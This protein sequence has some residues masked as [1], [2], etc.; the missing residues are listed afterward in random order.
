MTDTNRIELARDIEL[1]TLSA[2]RTYVEGDDKKKERA[3]AEHE[4][5]LAAFI[6]KYGSLCVAG[7]R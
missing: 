4:A 3:K 1:V 5:V 2:K 6:E 7:K